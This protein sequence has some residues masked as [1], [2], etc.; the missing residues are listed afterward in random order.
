VVDAGGELPA[1]QVRL[2]TYE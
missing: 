1:A 2:L